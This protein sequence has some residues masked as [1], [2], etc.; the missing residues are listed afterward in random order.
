[1]EIIWLLLLVG[2]IVLEMTTSQLIC[3][4]FA[5][6]ALIASIFALLNFSPAVQTTVFVLISAFLLIFTKKFVNKLKEKSGTK[7]N[8]DALIGQSAIVTEDISNINS[9]GTVKLS[10]LEWSAR[11]VDGTDIPAQS[12]VTIKN[13]DGVKLLVEKIN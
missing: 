13:I 9:K 3:I 1:M 6:G 11:S 7:T 8:V 2:F 12:Q 4:W 10:G 5:G